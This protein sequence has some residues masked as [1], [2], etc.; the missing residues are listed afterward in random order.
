MVV[1]GTSFKIMLKLGFLLQ[2]F[3]NSHLHFLIVESAALQS[4]L[5]ADATLKKWKWL[6]INGCKCKSQIYIMMELFII[7]TNPQSKSSVSTTL[8]FLTLC[9]DDTNVSFCWRIV[10]RNNCSSLEQMSRV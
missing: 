2:S 3:L 4:Y 9:Q 6:F 5:S 8:K 1:Q 10:L 7:V